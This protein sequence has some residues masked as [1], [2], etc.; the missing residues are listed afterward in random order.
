LLPEQH[1]W[2]GAPTGLSATLNDSPFYASTTAEQFERREQ[3]ACADT[4]VVSKRKVCQLQT[5][6]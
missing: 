3:V 4:V 2:A 5:S 1:W 6:V